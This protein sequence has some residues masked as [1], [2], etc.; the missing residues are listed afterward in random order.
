MATDRPKANKPA[1]LTVDLGSEEL[2]RLVRIAAIYRRQPL[3]EIVT[4]ALWQ[5]LRTQEDLFAALELDG[6]ADAPWREVK[7]ALES[8]K[9]NE[10]EG[11]R[12]MFQELRELEARRR[13]ERRKAG[14]Q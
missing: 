9:T 7:P 14:T 13:Q 10:A 1:R 3:R 5:W 11:R 4:E 6:A 12:R 2:Y 8:L